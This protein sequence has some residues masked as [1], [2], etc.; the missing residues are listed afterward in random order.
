MLLYIRSLLTVLKACEK[1]INI[2]WAVSPF[3]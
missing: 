3:S 2:L 1:S